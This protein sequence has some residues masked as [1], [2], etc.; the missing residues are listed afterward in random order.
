[1]KAFLNSP[2]NTTSQ[3]TFSKAELERC[4]DGLLFG[5]GNAQLPSSPLLMLDRIV[6]IQATGGNYDRGFAIAE[7]DVHQSSWF[8]KH[9][10]P[11]DPVMPGCLLIESLWQLTGFHM[12]WAGHKGRGRVL[13]SGRTRFLEPITEEKQTLTISI[14][15]RKIIIKENPIYISNGRILSNGVLSCRSDA[16]K[17]GLFN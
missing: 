2:L 13:E 14:Q 10:F 5:F 1:M 4:A 11:G 8:F 12:A 9:H 7:L 17:V 3:H 6:D 16:I 15:V